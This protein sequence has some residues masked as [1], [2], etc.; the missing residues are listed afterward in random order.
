MVLGTI[1]V[2]AFYNRGPE[3]QKSLVKRRNPFGPRAQEIL[4]LLRTN[5]GLGLGALP[6]RTPP[7]SQPTTHHPPTTSHWPSPCTKIATGHVPAQHRAQPA[8][9]P[10]VPVA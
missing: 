2:H 4:A 5:G 6:L 1:N 10:C 3:Q 9:R 8:A 7:V